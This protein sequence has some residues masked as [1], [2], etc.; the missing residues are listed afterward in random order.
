ME[1]GVW[2][3]PLDFGAIS[4]LEVSDTQESEG[5]GEEGEESDKGDVSPQSA[6]PHHESDDGETE[7]ENADSTAH[8]ALVTDV[9][10]TDVE[11]RDENGGVREPEGAVSAEHGRG[12]RVAESESP[13][14]A[15]KLG[16][17]AVEERHPDHHVRWRGHRHPED[18]CV[19]AREHERCG[20]EGEES[21]GDGV[22][23]HWCGHVYRVGLNSIVI[24]HS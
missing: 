14:S 1:V 9:S 24:R 7:E 18:A 5:D 11:P 21:Q 8:V 2:A 13:H 4:T 20:S 22:R 19:H 12:K 17:T 10:L 16:E 23:C 15:Q 3:Y 6:E